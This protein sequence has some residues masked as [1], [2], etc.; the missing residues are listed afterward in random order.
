MKQI[1]NTYSL[2]TDELWLMNSIIHEDFDLVSVIA[3]ERGR[4][5]L[6][7]DEEMTIYYNEK[8]YVIKREE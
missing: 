2:D 4:L 6:R 1:Y 3:R 7:V 8:K 5:P